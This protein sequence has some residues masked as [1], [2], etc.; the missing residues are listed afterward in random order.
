MSGEENEICRVCYNM[1][2]WGSKSYRQMENE[3][4]EKGYSIKIED[5]VDKVKE[6]GEMTPNFI[7]LDMRPSN[8]CNFK[9]RTCSPEYSTRWVEEQKAWDAL[10]GNKDIVKDYNVFHSSF[11][12]SKDSIEN[13]K[14]IYIAGGETLY[15]EEMYV[16][17]D[18]I[19]NK[20][21]ININIHTN[22]SIMKFKK[23]D[24][25][26]LL[27]NFESVTFFIS[28]DG[29]GEVGEYVRT[30]FKWDLFCENMEKLIEIEKIN[31][32]FHHFFHY[33]SS[34]LNVFHFFTF[35]SEILE[36]KFINDDSQINYYP[37]RWPTYY[38]SINFNIKDKILDYYEKN[39]HVIKSDSLKI[40]IQNFI[41]FISK[42]NM[43]LDWDK[44]ANESGVDK[45][46]TKLFKEFVT[47]GNQFN[48]TTIPNELSYLNEFL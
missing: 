27:E 13:L 9:C 28:I 26:K 25:F 1:E 5:L 10:Y 43:D 31:K 8:V 18:E 47:F 4:Y 21:Q 17:L 16:F 41:N 14:H 12:I 38:N 32:N 37:V 48:K 42:A 6:D 46:A 2:E 24:V 45:N 30:G 34:I 11:G 22:F 3:E 33:T 20:S 23:Y 7:K 19:E 40:Q 36:R 44:E 35:Y 39:L 29:I 15:M